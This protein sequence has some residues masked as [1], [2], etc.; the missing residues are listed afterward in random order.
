MYINEAER[1]VL[2]KICYYGAV[3]VGKVD[4]LEAL[5]H[6]FAAVDGART[7]FDVKQFA[8]RA[9]LER[10]MSAGA[11]TEFMSAAQKAFGAQYEQLTGGTLAWVRLPVPT[12]AGPKS[13]ARTIDVFSAT[14]GSDALRLY[15]LREADAVVFVGDL[16]DRDAT[17]GAWKQ[18]RA[19]EYRGPIV[20]LANR[21]TDADELV[22]ALAYE[23]PAFAEPE[24]FLGNLDAFETAASLAFRRFT[25]T[26]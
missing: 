18:L 7:H 17:L 15:S 20:L 12:N 8:P 19:T 11:A 6:H 14:G 22:G 23:G 4:L 21:S 13:Y 24:G 26:N 10:S 5:Y 16:G 9:D 25:S 3:G 1:T 2:G